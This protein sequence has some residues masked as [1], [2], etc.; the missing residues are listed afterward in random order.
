MIFP[1]KISP[2]QLLEYMRLQGWILGPAT[3][4]PS[5]SFNGRFWRNT[6]PGND[7]TKPVVVITPHTWEYHAYSATIMKAL[8]SLAKEQGCS[9][10]AVATAVEAL[11]TEQ[12][13]KIVQSLQGIQLWWNPELKAYYNES[14]IVTAKRLLEME[15]EGLEEF[16]VLEV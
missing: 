6:P 1:S 9:V 15:S 7:A 10:S 11:Q 12:S 8:E 3:G 13:P 16:E 14:T 2:W 5:S 4:D